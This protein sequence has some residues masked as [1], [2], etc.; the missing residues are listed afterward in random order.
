MVNIHLKTM[1][2]MSPPRLVR[3][4][5]IWGLLLITANPTACRPQFSSLSA[6]AELPERISDPILESNSV[7]EKKLL[8]QQLILK[9]HLDRESIG[10]FTKLSRPDRRYLEQLGKKL[11][12]EIVVQ[13]IDKRLLLRLPATHPA[14]MMD[15][16]LLDDEEE[17]VLYLPDKQLRYNLPR[18]QLPDIL[19]GTTPS[20]STAFELSTEVAQPLTAFEVNRYRMRK[21]RATTAQ[22]SFRYFPDPTRTNNWPIRLAWRYLSSEDS[23]PPQNL[24][25]LHLAFPWLQNEEGFGV[26]ESLALSLGPPLG[27]SVAITNETKPSGVTPKIYTT[28][29]EQKHII[30]PAD[31]FSPMRPNYRPG[32]STH[33]RLRAG[34]QLIPEPKLMILRTGP[35]VSGPLHIRNQSSSAAFIYVDGICVGWVGPHKQMK[36]KGLPEGFYRIYAASPTALRSWGPFDTYIPGPI[37]LR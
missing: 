11:D 5:A 6:N 22:I 37:T 9:N 14:G 29:S 20:V 4:I 8:A 1:I 21:I 7:V 19:D 16:L 26:L 32:R 31:N 27:W 3:S 2:L 35:A 13:Q 10:T 33:I 25:L 15:I 12:T 34:M 36:F 24:S 17:L 28:I 23:S 30:A 18:E